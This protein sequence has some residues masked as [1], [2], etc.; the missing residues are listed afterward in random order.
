VAAQRSPSSSFKGLDI[1]PKI[2]EIAYRKL[3]KHQLAIPLELYNGKDFPFESNSFDKVYSCL[4]FHHLD[5]ET[6]SHSFR[7]ILR[8]LKP[9]GNLV[10]GD[11]G[12]AKSKFMRAAFYTVQLVDGF[13]N[14]N[15]NVKGLLPQYM[16]EAGFFDVSEKGFINTKIGSFSYY[17]GR[18][19]T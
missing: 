16:S 14:T 2:R 6:K 18:K 17:Q 9:G 7:E 15:D 5:S 8:V 4:V 11:W 3:Q 13:N 19:E 1:D 12:K 10:I